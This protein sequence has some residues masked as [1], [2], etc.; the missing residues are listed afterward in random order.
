MNT[1]TITCRQHGGTF[2][3]PARR[4][5]PPVKCTTD[6][7]CSSVKANAK[8]RPV[9]KPERVASEIKN[10]RNDEAIAAAKARTLRTEDL[11]T[12]TGGP[13]MPTKRVPNY[14]N[15]G[16]TKG[17]EAKARLEALGWK[18]NGKRD[19]ENVLLTATRGDETLIMRWAPMGGLLSQEYSLWSETPSRNNK[20]ASKLPFDPDEVSDREL[21]RL[22]AGTKITWWNALGR[23][24]ETAYVS[25][26]RVQVVHA[27]DGYGDEQPSD[28]ILTFVAVGGG[29]RSLRVGAL[30]KVG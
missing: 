21:I 3:I 29:F 12:A 2:E 24:E 7:P 18:V 1:K 4:G 6:N 10:R 19:G 11:K 20:P 9:S 22:L 17:Q 5:R 13:L 16:V 23:S 8:V 25:P 28:R 27:Y 30:L 15:E 14:A 26:D